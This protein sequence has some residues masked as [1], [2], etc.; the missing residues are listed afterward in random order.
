VSYD[1]SVLIFLTEAG[2]EDPSLLD[3]PVE[4][5][6]LDDE[7]YIGYPGHTGTKYQW[8]TY[9]SPVNLPRGVTVSVNDTKAANAALLVKTS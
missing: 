1:G 3:G 6:E 8:N 9:F 7:V 4:L 2:H 5:F